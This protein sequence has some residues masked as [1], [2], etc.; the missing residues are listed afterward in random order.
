MSA[1]LDLSAGRLMLAEIHEFG[2]FRPEVQKYICRSLDVAFCPGAAV[3]IWAQ[4]E[5]EAEGIHAQIEIYEDLPEIGRCLPREQSHIDAD[6]VL[7]PLI[8]LTTFDLTC[9]PIG[10][11]VAYRFLY[12]RLLGADVRPWLPAAF[13][14]AASLPHLPRHFRRALV[15]SAAMASDA[16]WSMLEPTFFPKWLHEENVRMSRFTGANEH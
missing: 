16:A 10:S 14:A 9:S 5:R 13:C 8:A 11:F 15:E 4:N 1:Q 2:T 6:N 12:E 3:S 7:F